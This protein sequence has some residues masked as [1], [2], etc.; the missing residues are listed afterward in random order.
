MRLLIVLFAIVLLMIIGG[1]LVVDFRKDSATVE[2][3][4]DKMKHDASA[5]VEQASENLK[6]ASEAINRP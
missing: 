2:V 5:V 1:W 3:R 4:T 6:N